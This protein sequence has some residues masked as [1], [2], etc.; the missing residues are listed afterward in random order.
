MPNYFHKKASKFG[1]RV[2]DEWGRKLFLRFRNLRG[3]FDLFTIPNCKNFYL[4]LEH[5]S[6]TEFETC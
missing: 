2:M 3:V 1:Y 4:V 6:H 5:Y